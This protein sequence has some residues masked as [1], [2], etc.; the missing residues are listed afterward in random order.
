M[1]YNLQLRIPNYTIMPLHFS[2]QSRY[3]HFFS[4]SFINSFILCIPSLSRKEPYI[5]CNNKLS[6]SYKTWST[7]KDAKLG[8]PSQDG[9]YHN[10]SELD[11]SDLVCYPHVDIFGGLVRVWGREL[12]QVFKFNFTDCMSLFTAFLPEQCNVLRAPLTS[13]QQF[14]LHYIVIRCK[15]IHMGILFASFVYVN[16]K[17]CVQQG[18]GDQKS[19]F[20]I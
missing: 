15:R 11:Y 2:K 13:F 8:L 18:R 17:L 14:I 10:L 7:G 16:R 3:A 19:L 12:W 1:N 6:A 20:L 9:C 4:F 5:S